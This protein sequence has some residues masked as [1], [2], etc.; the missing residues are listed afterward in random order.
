MSAPELFRETQTPALALLSVSPA[1]LA[2]VHVQLWLALGLRLPHASRV[3]MSEGLALA[4][5]GPGRYLA[6]QRGPDPAPLEQMRKAVQPDA[7]VTD[8]SDAIVVLHLS[9]PEWR[10]VLQQMAFIDCHPSRLSSCTALV[11]RMGSIRVFVWTLEDSDGVFV[12]VPRSLIGSFLEL[13]H[14]CLPSASA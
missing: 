9:S 2:A 6:I 14:A 5:I 4:C 7:A 3:I 10:D 8:Y 13:A 1:K 11:T 12:G